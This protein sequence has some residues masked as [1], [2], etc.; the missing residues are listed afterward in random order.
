MQTTIAACQ[1]SAH[2]N[3]REALLAQYT[4]ALVG[5]GTKK[6]EVI[7]AQLLLLRYEQLEDKRI[8]VKSG[9]TQ[10]FRYGGAH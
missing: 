8:K 3:A 1:M 6:N 4:M 5:S 9:L 2:L 10:L 7:A